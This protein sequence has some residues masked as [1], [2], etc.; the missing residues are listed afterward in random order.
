MYFDGVQ[1]FGPDNRVNFDFTTKTTKN[2]LRELHVLRGFYGFYPAYC[3][4][5]G[6]VLNMNNRI[7]PEK[8]RTYRGRHP[9]R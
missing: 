9:D 6:Q 1:N 5:T 8:W 2:F 4:K 7:N 3:V